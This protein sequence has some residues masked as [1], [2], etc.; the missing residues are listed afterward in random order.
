MFGLDSIANHNSPFVSVIPVCRS[1]PPSYSLQN[2][3]IR[4]NFIN[5]ENKKIKPL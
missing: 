3:Y 1:D 5:K 4:H 2:N